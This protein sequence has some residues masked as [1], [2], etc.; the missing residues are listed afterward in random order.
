MDTKVP[1]KGAPDDGAIH[2]RTPLPRTG[3]EPTTL[4]DLLRWRAFYQ[5]K[6]QAYAFLGD[7]EAEGDSAGYGE[8]AR[9]ARAV[10]CRL[11]TLGVAGGERALLFYPPGLEYVA[12]FL[13]CLYAGVV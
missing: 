11:Q 4:V 9:Q 3:F 6:W 8:L 1:R 12:A 5:P 2:F 13:G 7:G 10:A